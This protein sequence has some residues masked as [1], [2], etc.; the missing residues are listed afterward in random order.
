MP[1]GVQS[2]IKWQEIRRLTNVCSCAAAILLLLVTSG[3]PAG[4]SSA[5]DRVRPIKIGALT[6]SWGPTPS[7]VGLRDGLVERGYRQ[8]EQFEIG[9]R[10]T[11]GDVSAL[12]AAAQDLVRGSVDIIFVMGANAAKAAR[13]TTTSIPIVFAGAVGDPV[14]LGLVGS[15]ARPGGNI[16][17]VTD[18]DVDLAPK[19]LEILQE[20]HPGL[21]RVLFAYDPSDA[22]GVATVR[23]YREAARRLGIALVEKTIRTEDAARDLIKLR[24]GEVDGILGASTL[25]MNIP[26]FLLEAARQQ[27]I[28]SMFN[29]LFWVERLGALASYGP[30]LY[31]SGR[32][33]ARLVDRILRGADPA[34]VP[35][36]ANPKI[37]LA[38][39]MKTAKALGL[40]IPPT[41]LLRANRVVQ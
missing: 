22:Y 35:V 30:D 40:A 11:Q 34:G 23:G 17:G 13:N 31:E 14:Q 12:P 29:D 41:V 24:K 4:A 32:L 38:I 5:A 33:A 20:M 28:P 16:T 36:E 3:I 10:F 9:V 21:K 8:G 18:L 37:E 6:D 2:D 1:G 15:F 26:G 25:S 19:R 7:I 39:N 27:G